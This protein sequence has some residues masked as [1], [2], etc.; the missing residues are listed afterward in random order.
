MITQKDSKLLRQLAMQVKDI[1]ILPE[2]AER[3]EKWRLHNSLKS[4]VPVIFV[5]P[6][7]AWRELLPLD[8]LTCE[9][10]FA[11]RIE[12]DLKMRIIRHQY[13]P[14]D[15][16]IEARL[17]IQKVIRNSMW[18]VEPQRVKSHQASGAWHFKSIINEPSDWKQ[19]KEPVVS[20]DEPETH[21]RY[22]AIQ[23][24]L[25]DILPVELVGVT[26]FSFHMMHWY[27]DYRGLE[28]MMTDLVLEPEMVHET[29]RFFT[30]GAKSMLHQYE[31]YNLISLNND[32]TFHYTG[33]VGYTDELPAPGF[34]P[35]RVRLCDVWGAAEAQ[36]F[37]TVSPDMHEEF[38]LSYERELLEYFGM[39]GYGC[40][41]DLGKKLDGVLKIKNLRRVAIS[42]WAD[43][44]DFTSR[45]QKNYI[46]TWKP[47]P[48]YLA[49]DQM[50]EASIRNELSSGLKKSRGGIIELILRDTH[51]CRF[52]P[53]RFTR[54]IEIAKECIKREMEMR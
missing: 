51:T 54:W 21:K 41:D 43:I 11:K 47:Q 4:E 30:E 46:M 28:N 49:F 38:I 29:I 26:Q 10:D 32:E 14:D 5:D 37:S 42:P 6:D 45:L 19:L 34:S 9:T 12:Y 22:A 39:N 33:G 40:C 18:G 1:S 2:Q 15:V 3:R 17:Q 13:L 53:K 8:S 44:S 35:K 36:E 25:G 16:P 27:C 52:D 48:S 20:Y 50:D 31:K 24:T 7:G 23:E